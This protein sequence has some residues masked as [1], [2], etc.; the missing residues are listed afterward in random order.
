MILFTDEHPPNKPP[1]F[2]S[3]PKSG[4]EIY[5]EDGKTTAKHSWEPPTATDAEDGTLR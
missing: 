1:Y 4:Q 3:C 2:T 5:A